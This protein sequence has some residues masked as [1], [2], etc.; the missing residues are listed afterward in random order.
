MVF[1]YG[2]YRFPHLKQKFDTKQYFDMILWRPL[3]KD[4][5]IWSLFSNGSMAFVILCTSRQHLYGLHPEMI[6]KIGA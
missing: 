5:N 2:M 6:V 3:I 4:G 1:E